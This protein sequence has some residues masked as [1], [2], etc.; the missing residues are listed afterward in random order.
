MLKSRAAVQITYACS[1]KIKRSTTMRKIFIFLLAIV[2]FQSVSILS[3]DVIFNRFGKFTSVYPYE[4]YTIGTLLGSTTPTKVSYNSLPIGFEFSFN[5]YTHT[6]FCVNSNGYISFDPAIEESFSALRNGNTNNIVAAMNT[7]LARNINATLRYLTLGTAPYRKTVVQWKGF[8]R[9]GASE[10]LSFQIVLHETSNVID[11]HYGASSYAEYPDQAT[12]VVGL[13]GENNSDLYNL[14][15]VSDWWENT[16]A[17]TFNDNC[18]LSSTVNPPAGLQI[19][20]EPDQSDPIPNP[21]FGNY[22]ADEAEDIST[23]VKLQWAYIGP[24]INGYKVFLGTDNPPS[25]VLN[26]IEI[27]NPAL[28]LI[29]W[30]SPDTEYYWQIIPFN[31]LHNAPNCPIWSFQT[32]SLPS[33]LSIPYYQDVNECCINGMPAGWLSWDNDA[34]ENTWQMVCEEA[35]TGE[36]S[37]YLNSSERLTMDDWLISPP[38]EMDNETDYCFRAMSKAGVG[39]DTSVLYVYWGTSPDPVQLQTSGYSDIWILEGTDYARHDFVVTPL[40]NGIYYFAIQASRESIF[41]DIWVDDLRVIDN[42]FSTANDPLAIP[43][44]QVKIKSIYPNPFKSSVNVEIELSK[45]APVSLEIYNTKG[46]KILA[47]NSSNPIAGTNQLKV[48]FDSLPQKLP[49]GDRKS[50]V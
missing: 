27:S 36:N 30:I 24:D 49:A 1:Q 42:A 46:Q 3:A 37:I 33:G 23:L 22:P 16:L 5:G 10:S 40:E 45:S 28:S 11:L 34:D 9:S 48:D 26:G 41:G 43:S 47:M 50:V 21:A 12:V 17:P 32:S 35:C 13:R 38:I 8:K 4:E 18:Q 31:E 44:P 14:Y 19:T 25:N 39:L 2:L 29:N 20:F 7:N 15:V 6:Q